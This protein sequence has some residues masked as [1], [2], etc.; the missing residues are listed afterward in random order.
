MSGQET[1][2]WENRF[3]PPFFRKLP[4]SIERGE[5]IYVWDERGRQYLDFTAG[6]GVTSLGHAHP[7]I[8]Q[9]LQQQARQIWQ[10]PNAGLV[11]NPTRARLL[12]LMA[13]ILPPPLT[14]TFFCTSGSE[15]IDAAIKL[16]RKVTGRMDI[17]SASQGFHGRM[18][19]ASSATGGI[20]HRE[21]IDPQASH[22]R[23]VSYGD[24]GE[25]EKAI[26]DKVAAVIME[27]ILG[28]GGVF[29]PPPG[30]LYYV[31]Q[32]CRKYGA[33][34]IIDEVQ[35]G[36]CRTGPMF[37]SSSLNLDV[38]FLTMGKGIASG[39]PFA[40]FAMTE[41]VAAKIEV[42]DHGGTYAGNPLGCAVAEAVVRYLIDH[43]I[44]S[45][46]EKMGGIFRT[47]LALL[48]NKYP[49]VIKEVRGQGL[50]WAAEISRP[51]QAGAVF[52][53]SLKKGLI[54]NI[55]KEQVIRF[56]PALVITEKQIQEGLSIFEE[57]ICE[58]AVDKCD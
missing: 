10:T 2:D 28:E 19:T 15:A 24:E 31:S 51:E 21:K 52:D 36:F 6:W 54:L 45:H 32:L 26:D 14:R 48:Q 49:Y 56:F 7:V 23:F 39:F 55:V 40:A 30:Y 29:V 47:G 11:C 42:G 9:A 1:L 43:D 57:A 4:L 8:L 58:T 37:A 33:L 22:F 46:V 35:T 20:G 27:P 50:L 13:N 18:I 25:V 12:A 53:A 3:S 41:E 38:S 34:L 16:A 5:G 44:S 17:V